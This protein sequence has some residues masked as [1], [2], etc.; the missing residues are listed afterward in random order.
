MQ[1]VNVDPEALPLEQDTDLFRP[2]SRSFELD[3][4]HEAIEFYYEQG[5]TDGLPV[6]PPTPAKV[7]QFLQAGGKYPGDIVGMIPE[8]NR[9][10]TAEKVAINAIMAGC[11][12]DYM[13]V[14]IAA[15]EA[16]CQEAFNCHGSSASTGGSAP[17][18]NSERPG[19]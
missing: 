2:T 11:L 19:G 10:I 3:N 1:T 13:P 8:R 12:A 16:M 9:V 4:L 7:S 18:N 6:V 5:W 17:F 14:V 15:I